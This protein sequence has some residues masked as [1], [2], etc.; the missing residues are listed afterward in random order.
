[1]VILLSKLYCEKI[2]VN[3]A[4]TKIKINIATMATIDSKSKKNVNY[5]IRAVNKPHLNPQKLRR[6]IV[7]GVIIT[8]NI[9]FL[10]TLAAFFIRYSN[11]IAQVGTNISNIAKTGINN[12]DLPNLGKVALGQVSDSSELFPQVN[13]GEANLDIEFS[14]LS[15]IT[16]DYTL[17]KFLNNNWAI[18]GDADFNKDNNLDLLL[19]NSDKNLVVTLSTLDKKIAGARTLPTINDKN[20]K[21]ILTNDFNNDNNA[22]L[23]WRY[24]DGKESKLLIWFLKDRTILKQQWLAVD[25]QNLKDWDIVGSGNFDENL[26]PDLVLSYIGKDTRFRGANLVAY[27][28]GT[29]TIK[30]KAD[31]TTD[32]LPFI[33]TVDEVGNLT[34]NI[35][36]VTDYNKDGF[37]DLILAQNDKSKIRSQ[38]GKIE[39]WLL[40]NTELS[41][42][43][44]L[45]DFLNLNNKP[46]FVD[47][48]LDGTTD[49]LWTNVDSNN[50]ECQGLT[51]TWL[52][53]GLFRLESE[54]KSKINECV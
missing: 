5:V 49:L 3:K 1:M 36:E 43:V 13:L 50:K 40:K 26:T 35:L 52:M 18:V 54:I 19:F 21:L 10:A 20:W 45:E 42:I 8:L 2:I 12:L 51:A 33:E 44:N 15:E 24:N 41:A 27:L 39:V 46:Y 25:V 11:N 17:P 37:P 16:V 47:I 23:L 48:N 34:K 31:K 7:L 4:I 32:W 53:K 6:W 22:D 38:Q 9:A 14:K 29:G 30:A 28:E